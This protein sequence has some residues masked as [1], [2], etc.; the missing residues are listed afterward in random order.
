MAILADDCAMSARLP[1]IGTMQMTRLRVEREKSSRQRGELTMRFAVLLAAMAALGV[2]P[3]KAAAIWTF[4]VQAFTTGIN[5][6]Y[7]LGVPEF[8]PVAIPL[9]FHVSLPAFANSSNLDQR[10]PILG[11]PTGL[12][13]RGPVMT[14]VLTLN[15]GILTG[16]NFS[17]MGGPADRGE[18]GGAYY[19]LSAPTFSVAFVRSSDTTAPVP[20][21]ATWALMLLGFGAIGWTMRQRSRRLDRTYPAL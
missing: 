2:Q 20:E 5:T 12:G 19:N 7:T 18:P 21:P 15:D 8:I 11:D 1:H 3:A 9:N 14:G 4:N 16:T 17:Y 10:F 13:S 6:P